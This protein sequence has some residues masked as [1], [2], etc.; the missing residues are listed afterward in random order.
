MSTDTINLAEFGSYT[1]EFTRLSQLLQDARY[2][3]YANGVVSR[4]LDEPTHVP[5]L[6]PTSWDVKTFRPINSSEY[7][8]LSIP[9]FVSF[10]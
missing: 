8:L 10:I 9:L 2:E 3:D 4:A 6:Y 5:G 1:L 7:S